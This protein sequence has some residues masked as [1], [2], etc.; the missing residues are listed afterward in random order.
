MKLIYT[1]ITKVKP[2][3]KSEKTRYKYSKY[4]KIVNKRV[5]S[6][7]RADIEEANKSSIGT[8]IADAAEKVNKS[9]KDINKTNAKVDKSGIN[10]ILKNSGKSISRINKDEINNQAQV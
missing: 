2:I 3:K 7:D 4:K 10:I 5:T 1:R 9:G 6:I 8:T